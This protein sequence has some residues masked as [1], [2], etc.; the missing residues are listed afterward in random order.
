MDENAVQQLWWAR[1]QTITTFIGLPIIIINI[2]S[3]M[4]DQ[5]IR[6]KALDSGKRASDAEEMGSF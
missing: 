2:F 4:Y 3:L 1:A 5:I 6:L